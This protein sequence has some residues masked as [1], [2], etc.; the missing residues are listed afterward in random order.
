MDELIKAATLVNLILISALTLKK[1][2][3]KD[4]DN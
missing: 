4:D 1:L 3:E 2:V